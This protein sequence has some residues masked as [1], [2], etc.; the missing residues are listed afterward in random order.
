MILDTGVEV[1]NL[2]CTIVRILS[3][4]VRILSVYCPYIVRILYSDLIFVLG[5]CLVWG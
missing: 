5:V 2:L 4:I 1:R 3:V